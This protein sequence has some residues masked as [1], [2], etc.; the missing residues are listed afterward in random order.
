L[1]DIAKNC[2]GKGVIVEIGSLLGKS[3]AYLGLGSKAG[4]G[5]KIYAIDPFDGGDSAPKSKGIKGIIA[6]GNFLIKFQANIER[7]A[8]SDI[9][10]PIAKRSKD[11][12]S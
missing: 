4:V 7:A 9:I 3:T 8:L 6:K 11:A 5:V 1:Y 2:V 12:M 10:V